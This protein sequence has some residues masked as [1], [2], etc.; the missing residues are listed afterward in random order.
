MTPSPAASSRPR[1]ALFELPLALLCLWAA[2]FHTPL[3]ALFRDVGAHVLGRHSSARPL[4][5]Y[6]SGGDLDFGAPAGGHDAPP[7]LQ[8][9]R[10]VS[11]QLALGYGLWAGLRAV[12]A[13]D[14]AA[15]RARLASWGVPSAALE[16]EAQGPKA[17]EAALAQLTPRFGSPD[18]AVLAVFAGEEPVRFAVDR[19]RAAG[20]ALELEAL[21][22]N[23][24]PGLDDARARAGDVLALGTAYGLSW[25]LAGRSALSSGFGMRR[26]P[27][28]GE[29]KL[30][31][32]IDLPV[33][34]GTQ[35]HVTADGV[36]RRASEDALNGRMLLIDHGHGVTTA[37]L[38]NERLL[39]SV[40]QAVKRGQ[41]ISLS[42]STGRSTGPHLH[43]QLELFGRPVD[44]LAFRPRAAGLVRQDAP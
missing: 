43:Y 41:V 18:A 31:T 21:A 33:P 24:P 27:V 22:R 37:Y 29:A 13:K 44:P 28:L 42:G 2:Y 16:S 12:P 39:V 10:P 4:L 5:A 3:G 34:R 30:H 1:R 26:H 7:S 9:T 23:L 11:P 25:P 17:L 35:V 32:G 20:G 15:L 19:T 14:Q 6:Y 38:H 36:V 40:G 8:P